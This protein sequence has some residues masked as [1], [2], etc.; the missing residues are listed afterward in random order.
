MLRTTAERVIELVVWRRS[1]TE[2]WEGKVCATVTACVKLHV[3]ISVC[4]CVCARA[5]MDICKRIG[6]GEREIVHEW[7][8]LGATLRAVTA[9]VNIA[10]ADRPRLP[11]A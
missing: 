3:H 4:M 2:V 1:D 10:N 8:Q 11:T 6:G 5:Y 7:V 9:T